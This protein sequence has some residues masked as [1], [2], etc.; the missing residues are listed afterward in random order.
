MREKSTTHSE[1][2]ILFL[3]KYI[4][5]DHNSKLIKSFKKDF[6]VIFVIYFNLTFF[7]IHFFRYLYKL[8]ST[9]QHLF[10]FNNF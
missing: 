8:R 6:T 1:R 10:P 2:N 9:G 7:I 5:L 3:L 4:N